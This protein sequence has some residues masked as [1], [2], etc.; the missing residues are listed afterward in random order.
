MCVSTVTGVGLFSEILELHDT[1]APNTSADSF[2]SDLFDAR[3]AHDASRPWYLSFT[4]Y[5]TF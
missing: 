4:V 1:S 5:D 3:T 2:V